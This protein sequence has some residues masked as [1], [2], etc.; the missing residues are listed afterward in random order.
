MAR[1]P[2]IQGNAVQAAPLSR[3]RLRAADTGG[4][5]AG[6]GAGMQRLGDTLGRVAEDQDRL[7]QQLDNAGAKTLD[8][9]ARQELDKVLSGF[10]ATQGLNAGAARPDV[11]TRINEIRETFAARATTPRM[12]AMLADSL[13][14]QSGDA[15]GKVDRHTRTQ[16]TEAEKTA[17]AA[18]AETLGEAAIYAA[19]PEERTRNLTAALAE[20]RRLG[21]LRG[22]APEVTA[23][24][25]KTRE[26]GVH[27]SVIRNLVDGDDLDAAV[28]YENTHA[29]RLTDADRTRIRRMML[30]PLNAR[31]ADAD[32][33]AAMVG[34]LPS[35]APADGDVATV[36]GAS[37]DQVF[38][39][40]L[41][42]E[43][44]NQA[45]AVGPD[46][47]WGNAY[48]AAQVLDSTARGVAKKLGIAWQP[49]LMRGKSREAY[50]YQVK[51]GRGYFD[52]GLEKHGG[53]VRKALM[54]F[55][56]GPN[57]RMW[58][59]KTRKYVDQVMARVPG[60][61]AS[62]PP[63]TARR[64]DVEGVHTRLDSLAQE[65]GWSPERL[66]R[67][68]RSADRVVDRDEGLA[69]RREQEAQRGALEAIDAL[70]G[71]RLTSLSQLPADVR[72]NLSPSD[73]MRFEG[74]IEENNKPI[75]PS[76]NGPVAANL[77][78]LAASDP[79]A[80]MRED[81]RMY[82]NQMTPGEFE[83]LSVNQARM[84]AKP[85]AET[86]HSRIWGQIN[87]F[88]SDVGLDLGSNKGKPRKP[89]D[90]AAAMSI[91]STMQ[92][93]LNFLTEGKRVPT[94]DEVKRA[95]D[96]A[97]MPVASGGAAIPRFR[98][99]GLPTNSIAI[100]DA[101]RRRI[102]NGLRA[103]G[104]PTDYRTIARVYVEGR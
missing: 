81:L 98:A 69:A 26:S 18:R 96:N 89:E 28:E 73:R 97:V 61:S 56:G 6:L 85:A 23:L 43:S 55:H 101:D 58:G 29:T 71:N 76:A 79:A 35:D 68:K 30:D 33:A 19:T 27:A 40:L 53:D 77:N 104:L 92:G 8:V 78:I 50:A 9:Q 84:L 59:P 45:G 1:V 103:A 4:A 95:F 80:F 93:Y 24:A 88:A 65:Q 42:Q 83:S 21:E 3:E 12:R 7:D 63:A 100:P 57:Q 46:T 34:G 16:L 5:M 10:A 25:Q 15:L 31:Q 17:T 37:T 86:P 51:I 82:R 60:G 47:P 54:Y 72:A 14:V 102:I 41:M 87:R 62:I 75:A 90:R 13:S 11:E 38:Q 66:A 2:V 91:F 99:T 32:A 49:E 74:M 64:W 36:G 48:G 94:D 20:D 39:A 22:D 70:P 52:E 67:A 44:G